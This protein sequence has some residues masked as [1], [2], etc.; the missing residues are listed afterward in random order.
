[1]KN[2]QNKNNEAFISLNH[3]VKVYQNNEKAVYDFDLDIKRN[4]F[5]VI[6]GP[7]G[8]GKSTT[9]RMIAGLEDITEGEIYLN[10]ELLNY[11]PSSE[12]R[13]AIVF[14]S[15]ALYPHMTVYENIAFPLTI[16]KY[17][18][19]AVDENLLA[20][21]EIEK[22]C[23]TVAF[24]KFAGVMYNVLREKRKA[25]DR[26][27]TVATVFNASYQA[28]KLLT[29]V[30]KPYLRDSLETLFA[31]ETE[32]LDRLRQMLADV[33]QTAELKNSEEGIALDDDFCA[34]DESGRKK[35][36]YRKY[37]P[38]EIKTRVY[39]IA[40]K[41]DLIPYLDKLPKELSGGQMQRV[42]LGR[43]IVKNV[44]VFLMDEPLSNLDAKLRLTMRSEIV[45]LHNRIGSTTIYVTHDQTEAMTMATRIVVMSRGF[46]QQIGTPEEIYDRPSNIFV[47]KFIGSPAMNFFDMRFDRNN[48]R[49]TCGEFSIPVDEAFIAKHDAVYLRE[50][51]K[52][53]KLIENF[54]QSARDEIRKTLSATGELGTARST[55]PKKKN[56]FVRTAAFVKRIVEKIKKTK[57]IEDPF[58]CERELCAAKLKELE[59]CLTDEHTV[60]VGIRPERIRIALKKDGKNKS[61]FTV[62]PTVCE[63]LGGEYNIHFDFCG[64]DMVSRTDTARK[65]TTEDELVA[66]FSMDDAYVF[67]PITGSTIR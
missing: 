23:D 32:I 44:P 30:F 40:E 64:R 4:E 5:I 48:S 7:S 17:P 65:I 12:R 9:L 53:Q 20:V 59:A 66:S 41:L 38:F 3:L 1:M 14:Q 45:K 47:A 36:V 25:S 22:I 56:I 55:K 46:V 67:D 60:S 6:V 24:N 52:Y 26:V 42:A 18:L 35:Y 61:G 31:K 2:I 63:L 19:P 54:D 43:A 49:L 21:S 39:D 27:E 58:G 8:C 34:V 29:E 37:T 10:G 28:G 50:V 13:M 57:K 62:K 15:Y 11:K 33:K 51:E 16:K